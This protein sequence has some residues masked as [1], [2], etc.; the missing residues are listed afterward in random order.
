MRWIVAILLA[1]VPM[2]ALADSCQYAIA[3]YNDAYND[4][5]STLPRYT[6]CLRDESDDPLNQKDDCSSEFRRVKS[7]QS[8]LESAVSQIKSYCR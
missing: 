4:L 7:A 3:E 8:D 1:C 6:S 2:V 5:S